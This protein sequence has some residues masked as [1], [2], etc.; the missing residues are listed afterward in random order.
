MNAQ[1][2][3]A[4]YE[5]I[6][7][8][9]DAVPRLRRFIL[10]LA[11]RGML[12]AQDRSDKPAS[13]LIKKVAKETERLRKTGEFREPN[14]FIR[15]ERE[16]LTFAP[17][18]HWAW[19]RLIEIS[20]PSYGFAFASTSF[21]SNKRGMPLI[22]IRDISST[23][24]ETYFDGDFDPA[25]LVKAGDYLVGMDGD[26][27]VR[28]WRGPDGLLNQRVLRIKEWRCEIEPEF[29]RLPLQFILD[30]LHRETSL[31]TVKHLSAKQVNGIE[32]PL[33]P[34]AE[35][36][37]IV[38]KVTELMGLCDQLEASQRR[39]EAARDLLAASS[40]ARL[41][42]PDPKT[43]H[44]D[45][46][47]AL[48][49]LA[50]LTTRTDQIKQLRQ[51]ILNLAVRGKLVQQDS[52]NEP[53]LELLKRFAKAKLERKNATNDARI[54]MEPDPKADELELTLP[55]GWAVQSFENLFLFIDYRGN[56][57]PKTEAGIPLI[58]AKNIR[59]GYL[60]REPR[61]YISH[62]TFETW[63]TR[64]FPKA[65]DLFFTTEAPLANICLNNINEPFALAQR[66]ICF[67]P[68]AKIDTRFLMFAL[69]SDVMQSLIDKH[70]TGMTAKGIKAAKLKPLPIPIPPLA[71]Q[72]QIVTKVDAL[73]ELCD[74][75]EASL[76]STTAIRRR[77]LDALLAEALTPIDGRELVAAE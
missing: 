16:S 36:H 34:V 66:A 9:P 38:A 13:E 43:F 71:E 24:T 18:P 59:M 3:L 17:P 46:C 28:R 14:S 75:L 68:Y 11:V 64:G 42:T 48:D 57:P 23:D 5:K 21:N 10:D 8:A 35:Q 65:G 41:N 58:T 4:H 69:M 55:P 51:T 1:R 7:G 40:L 76:T 47:F 52:K 39:C 19:A 53:A 30:D 60:N 74:R 67:Q 15:I 61:E 22:R 44:S 37:R 77:L 56:T 49:A 20:R 2:L 33:P 63:M 25:Y 73:M 32:I 45:S 54:K 6:A 70:A 12:V 50:A 29:V 72:H 31:T 27:N 62:A 26:F